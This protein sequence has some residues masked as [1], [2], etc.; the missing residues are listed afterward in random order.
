[1][2]ILPTGDAP[3]RGLTELAGAVGS[4]GSRGRERRGRTRRT[5]DR[6]GHFVGTFY[7]KTDIHE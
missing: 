7:E 5:E 1:M 3:G 6:V 4:E 2:V